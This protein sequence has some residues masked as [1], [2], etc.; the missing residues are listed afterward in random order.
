MPRRHFDLTQVQAERICIIKP[1]AL[2]DVVQTMPLIP[3]MKERFPGSS[4]S[5]VINRELSPL[6]EGHSQLDQIIP[7][8]RRGPLSSWKRTLAELR[9]GEFDLVFDL[10]GLARTAIMNLATR[11]PL[12]VGMESAREGARFTC[13]YSV[14]DTGRFVPAYLRYWRVAE[15]L[16]MKHVSCST[17]VPFTDEDRIWA[18]RQLATIGP[19]VLAIHP[20]ARWRTK[21]WP[22]ERFAVVA[23][24]AI[25]TY[26]Y[27]VAILG[28]P[29]ETQVAEQVERLINHF[30]PET[31]VLNLTGRTSLK[32]LAAILSASDICLTNDSGPMHLAAAV[33]TSVLGVFTC[34]TPERSGPPDRQHE[35]VATELECG[36]SYKKRCP[37]AGIRHM[38]CMEEL[39]T[40][41]V[42]GALRRLVEKSHLDQHR[43]AA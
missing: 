11:A 27:S 19:R 34:T 13:H 33:G 24:K 29:A 31:D 5:W 12:R 14:P 2:G 37:K 40:D 16:G 22:V 42:I 3:L 20:G 6:L 4:I 15:A 23:C 26:G 21:R 39:D 38:A 36:G 32:Q 43:R 17:E 28:S 10:Q 7:F 8:D 18:A 41:R 30:I 35:L 1:S 9:Q 25:R